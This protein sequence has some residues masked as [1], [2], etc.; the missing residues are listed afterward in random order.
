MGMLPEE[1][2][3]ARTPNVL[4]QSLSE[5]YQKLGQNF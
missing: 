3:I 4:K 1:L 2:L 5:I